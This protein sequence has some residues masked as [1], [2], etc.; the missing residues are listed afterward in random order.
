M[1]DLLLIQTKGGIV[2]LET[3]PSKNTA[4]VPSNTSINHLLAQA[5]LNETSATSSASSTFVQ[6]TTA[7]KWRTLKDIGLI[8]IAAYQK[9]V[10]LVWLDEFLASLATLFDRLYHSH[11]AHGLADPQ[12]HAGVAAILDD[13][14]Q[15]SCQLSEW[16]DQ[17]IASYEKEH[18]GLQT[19]T[20]VEREAK[21]WQ[22]D[23]VTTTGLS[24][25]TG[26]ATLASSKTDQRAAAFNKSPLHSP[27][28]SSGEETDDPA[29]RPKKKKGRKWDA[30]GFVADDDDGGAAVLDY[31]EAN[32][33]TADKS[34]AYLDK[35]ASMSGTPFVLRDMSGNTS[36]T[37]S[38]SES[39]VLS[40]FK[41]IIG[42][43][44]LHKADLDPVLD[45]MYIF[46]IEKNVARP[47]AEN[48][49]TNV[50]IDLENKTTGSWESVHTAVRN[51]FSRSL[52]RILT[53]TTPTSL[54][55]EIAHV[56][57]T[58]KRPYVISVV[59]VNGVGKSTS[60]SKIAYWLLSSNLSILLAACDTF[61]SGAVEQL[62]VHVKNLSQLH[63]AR[64]IELFSR[65]YGKDAA[66]VAKDAVETGKHDKFD[67]VLIDTAGRRH[68]DQR[69]M[70]SLEKFATLAKPDKILMV[71][72]ALVGTDS[73]HQARNF[74]AA[75]GHQR[76]LD[77]FI[78]SKVDT[79]GDM[80]GTIVSMTYEVGIPVL[81]VGVGQMYPDLRSLSVDWV[82][83]K[84]L[85]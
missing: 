76:S 42:G 82:V 44:T 4:A 22:M 49:M 63:G 2:L 3:R 14:S 77:G 35:M 57:T 45:K 75:L 83:E 43:K 73:L 37:S 55:Q 9:F 72:E 29:R 61:R 85:S 27:A 53:S 1:I 60:L 70:G 68:N 6:N 51:A 36:T 81:F 80:V 41:S 38:G 39:R 71:A 18:G 10:N 69:L 13:V 8:I 5:F 7:F 66:V 31:S 84:L 15:P 32:G 40:F 74:N 33:T 20:Y 64:R 16:I 58:L 54:L 62:A 65:G 56:N 79:V 78:I 48:I 46:L 25:S 23:K 28:V 47:V 11:L 52:T 30:D 12:Y 19:T 34:V 17:R 67:V 24:P 50:R 21:D 59:G 26:R